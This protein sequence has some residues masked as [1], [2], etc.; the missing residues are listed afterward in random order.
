MTSLLLLIRIFA[1]SNNNYKLQPIPQHSKLDD[2][3]KETEDM[4]SSGLLISTPS[5]TASGW[6]FPVLYV[7][8]QASEKRLC[9]QF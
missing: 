3:K 1:S 2:L 5:D 4:T 9:V 7:K 8:K 6:A